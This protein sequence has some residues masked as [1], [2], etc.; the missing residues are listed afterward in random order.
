[1]YFTSIN[2]SVRQF[3]I[4][5]KIAEVAGVLATVALHR[6]VVRFRA[7]AWAG[8]GARVNGACV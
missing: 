3:K 1:M 6:G 7:G 5:K 4:Q 2:T 8:L